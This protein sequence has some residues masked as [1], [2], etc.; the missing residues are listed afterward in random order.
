MFVNIIM[1]T[2]IM[3]IV[4]SLVI[5]IPQLVAPINENSAINYLTGR[6]FTVLAS[7]EYDLLNEKIDVI[8]LEE[9]NISVRSLELIDEFQHLSRIFP[10][11]TNETVTIYSSAEA[12]K[13]SD[14]QEFTDSSGNKFSDKVTSAVHLS[15][16]KI[17]YYSNKNIIY[18]YEIAYGDS[19]TIVANRRVAATKEADE[20]TID[21]RCPLIP[22]GERVYA[23][24]M[25]SAGGAS[26][27]ILLRYHY[28]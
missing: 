8:K 16:T 17:E 15:D 6:G 9:D 18:I 26:I 4:V 12:N 24:V 27:Q 25:S 28:H 22:V 10:E 13:W 1:G 23:R 19:K 21:L 20:Y 7:G 14:W 5:V 2:I 3:I 11:A